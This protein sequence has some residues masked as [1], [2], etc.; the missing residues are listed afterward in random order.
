MTK[1]NPQPT[2]ADLVAQREALERQIEAAEI[3]PLRAIGEALAKPAVPKALE[4]LQA[5]V[6][7]LSGERRKQAEN[8]ITVLTHCPAFLTAQ[9]AA[10]EERKAAAEPPAA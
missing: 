7:S 5:Q 8:L 6:E 3:A 9:L 10:I 4:V 2:L 1:P